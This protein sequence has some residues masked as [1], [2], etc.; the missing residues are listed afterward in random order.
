MSFVFVP[1]ILSWVCVLPFSCVAL[2]ALVIIVQPIW[3]EWLLPV[4]ES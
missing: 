3:R 4:M 2:S 1:I